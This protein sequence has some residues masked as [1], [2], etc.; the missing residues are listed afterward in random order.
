MA[1][2]QHQPTPQCNFGIIVQMPLIWEEIVAPSIAWVLII[3]QYAYLWRSGAFSK[4]LKLGSEISVD[5]QLYPYYFFAKVR[6]GWVLQNHLTGQA[7]ANTTRDY[8]RVV[9]FYAGNAACMSYF[10]SRCLE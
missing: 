5:S 8:L 4:H 3:G 2:S 10:H 9:L 1:T 7:A 6:E